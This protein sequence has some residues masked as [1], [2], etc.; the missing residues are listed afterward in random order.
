MIKQ[1]NLGEVDRLMRWLDLPFDLDKWTELYTLHGTRTLS[2]YFNTLLDDH[3]EA[4][5]WSDEN[6]R[7]EMARKEGTIDD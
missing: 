5:R 6:E 1:D 3:Y 2:A 4:L 7:W